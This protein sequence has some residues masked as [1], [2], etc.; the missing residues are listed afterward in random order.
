MANDLIVVSAAGLITIQDHGRRGLA[1]MGVGVSGAADRRSHDRANRLVG[2]L[3]SAATLEITFGRLRAFS[4]TMTWIAVTG[5]PAPV[6]VGGRDVAMNTRVPLRPGESIDIGTSSTG[7]RTYLAMRGGIDVDEVLGSRSTDTLAGLGP[8]PLAAG[9]VVA[10]GADLAE[11]PVADFIADRRISDPVNLTLTMTLGP[12]DD[13]FTPSAVGLLG[14]S[15]WTVDPSSNRVGVRLAGPSL[16]RRVT[17][18]LASE[19]V[20]VGSVQVPPAGPIVFLDDHP[21]TGGYPVIGVVD[22]RSLDH[23]AQ[24][25]PGDRVGFE[26]RPM[27]PPR[28]QRARH[29]SRLSSRRNPAG[30]R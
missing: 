9:D 1:S 5:A 3:E 4:S 13:W 27:E 20:P 21:V 6:R 11:F 30:S 12:R 14:T 26:I 10:I 8:A 15:T 17:T 25:R 7:L 16:E 28:Q 24:A 2:N 29:E 22:R 18:E 23:L 19:G